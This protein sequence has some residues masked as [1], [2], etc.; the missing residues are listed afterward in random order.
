MASSITYKEICGADVSN[1]R[2]VIIS[3][4][5]KGG[6]TIAQKL[7]IDEN[8]E[9]NAVFLKGA[10]HVDSVDKLIAL[11]DAINIAIQNYET[12]DA[13]ADNDGVN[14]DND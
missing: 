11:R 6:F 14:W 8:G 3:E 1:A 12:P 2:Q 9:P 13:D 7:T 5:S 4:C 10:I